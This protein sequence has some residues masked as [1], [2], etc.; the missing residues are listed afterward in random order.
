MNTL[1]YKIY[2]LIEKDDYGNIPSQIVDWCIIFLILLSITS[3]IIESYEISD[4]TKRLLSKIEI[5]TVVLFSIEYILRLWTSDYKYKKGFKSKLRY[6]ISPSAL[7]D[8]LA[9]LPFY[10]PFIIK[11]DLRFFR[12]LRLFRIFRL[13]KLSRYI[14]SMKIISNAI[15][16][17]KEELI[18]TIVITLFL[19]L[20]SSTLMFYIEHEQ[21][22]D[23]FTNIPSTFWWAI[24]TLTTVGYGDI[25]PVTSSGKILASIIAFLGIGLV[26]LP[27][28][29]IS[30]GFLEEISKKKKED[31][32]CPH[33]GKK[34]IR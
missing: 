10:L 5:I 14:E 17:R 27:T 1:K 8:L 13:L 34:I 23:K 11:V 6:I 24:A 32:I 26:A 15:K 21:Q 22:P 25:Y 19:I 20:F 28:G 3:I 18:I 16:N 30:S 33:C 2:K 7:I 29:I 12:M 9:I 31:I 4:F